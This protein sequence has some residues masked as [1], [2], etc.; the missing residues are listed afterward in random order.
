MFPAT[1]AARSSCLANG[2]VVRT[3]TDKN[4][5]LCSAPSTSPMTRSTMKLS[6]IISRAE[7][8]AAATLFP[9]TT[10]A[11][12]AR[13]TM[14]CGA[15]KVDRVTTPSNTKRILSNIYQI[16]SSDEKSSAFPLRH[17]RDHEV[18]VSDWCVLCRSGGESGRHRRMPSHAV[19]HRPPPIRPSA[20]AAA[21]RRISTESDLRS[22]LVVTRDGGWCCPRGHRYRC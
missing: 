3:D 17:R 16:R 2:A 12:A 22:A 15:V 4:A 20:P 19:A 7:R 10:S 9:T 8:A 1:G 14:R 13:A 5:A 11:I 18:G 21:V 6:G